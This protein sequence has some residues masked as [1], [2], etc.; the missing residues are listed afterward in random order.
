MVIEMVEEHKSFNISPLLPALDE[1][2]ESV[3]ESLAGVDHK[4]LNQRLTV[5][6][7][8]YGELIQT[9]DKYGLRTYGLAT[10][11][12]KYHSYFVVE[13][14]VSEPAPR[15]IKQIKIPFNNK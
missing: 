5:E 15:T 12:R 6:A 14:F 11:I 1:F 9:L 8:I 4:D 2:E 10:A 3:R 13:V 7:R